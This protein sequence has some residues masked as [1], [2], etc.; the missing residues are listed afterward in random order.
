MA[1]AS[2]ASL[3][4]DMHTLGTLIGPSYVAGRRIIQ[5]REQSQQTSLLLLAS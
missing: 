5:E 2:I 1:P 4:A 3:C